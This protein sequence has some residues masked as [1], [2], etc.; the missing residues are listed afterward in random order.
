MSLTPTP[1]EKGE[2]IAKEGRKE[3]KRRLHMAKKDV[4]ELKIDV[5][6]MKTNLTAHGEFTFQV[7]LKTQLTYFFL[8]TWI[9]K[10]LK[11]FVFF[12]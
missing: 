10:S 4:K 3:E 9:E 8:L 2:Q 7:E 5:S 1:N 11:L 12:T 6:F